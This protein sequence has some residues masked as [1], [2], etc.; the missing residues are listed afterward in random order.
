[1]PHPV[2]QLDA[3]LGEFLQHANLLWRQ[4]QR[5]GPGKIGSLLFDRLE[6]AAKGL[7]QSLEIVTNLDTAQTLLPDDVTRLS[8]F[9]GAIDTVLR[10]AKRCAC[11]PQGLCFV[12]G[13]AGL[14]PNKLQYRE[15]EN[16][17]GKLE[18]ER[19]WLR[20]LARSENN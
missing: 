15:F 6:L 13:E 8:E 9:I 4:Y 3:L 18:R 11:S 19:D 12:T 10:L 7:T 16:Q 20:Q 2:S 5:L 17:L 14:I 1:M